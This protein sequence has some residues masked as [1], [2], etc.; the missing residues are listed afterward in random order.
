MADLLCLSQIEKGTFRKNISR[1]NLEEA[2]EE[3]L[4]IQK[5]KADFKEINVEVIYIGFPGN[6]FEIVT[7][8]FRLQQVIL[9]YH[10]NAIKFTP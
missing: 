4:Y 10:N 3:I 8:K 1:F 2:V 5:E 6:N 7:D 9:Q